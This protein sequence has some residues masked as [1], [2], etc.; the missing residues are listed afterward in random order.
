MV[1]EVVDKMKVTL[2]LSIEQLKS[3]ISDT[4]I[5]LDIDM[6]NSK[7]Q[8]KAALVYLNNL[9]LSGVGFSEET[10]DYNKKKELLIEY[11]NLKNILRLDQLLYSNLHVI[12][13]RYSVTMCTEDQEF[14]EHNSFLSQEEIEQ[15]LSDETYIEALDRL[16]TML[17]NLP[18]YVITL[19]NWFRE[20]YPNYKNDYELI[21]DSNYIGFTWVHYIN[22]ELFQHHYSAF[23]PNKITRPKYFK[24]YYDDYIYKGTNLFSYFVKGNV[25]INIIDMISRGELTPE[26]LAQHHGELDNVTLG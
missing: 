13:T 14:L 17:N 15:L 10:L 23:V 22:D 4:T 3:A 20:A 12:F 19:A 26:T 24:T 7:I 8:G 11:I 5:V 25:M 18:Y 2:P 6:S 21:E 1:R 9:D 16:E